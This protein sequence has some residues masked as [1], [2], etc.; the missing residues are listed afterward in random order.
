MSRQAKVYIPP[1]DKDHVIAKVFPL[2][3][4]LLH[5]HNVCLENVK[6]R[7]PKMQVSIADEHTIRCAV[8]ESSCFGSM[9]GRKTDSFANVSVC[10]RNLRLGCHEPDAVYWKREL[11]SNAKRPKCP[12][13]QTIL[14]IPRC[15]S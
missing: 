11:A 5:D 10:V 15:D 4:G 9:V 3:L 13:S 8:P 2:N 7:L 14:T 1:W 6:H 12:D